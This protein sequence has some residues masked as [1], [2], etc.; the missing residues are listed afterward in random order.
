MWIPRPPNGPGRPGPGPGWSLGPSSPPRLGFLCHL[1]TIISSCFYV[2]CCCWLLED[3]FGGPRRRHNHLGPPI[4]SPEYPGP[5]LGPEPPELQSRP[6]GHFGPRSRP[7]PIGFPGEPQLGHVGPSSQPGPV[8]FP[9][10]PS[11]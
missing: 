5:I 9:G 1:C 6:L 11:Y 10:E 4:G 2:F 7:G 8:G 3:C